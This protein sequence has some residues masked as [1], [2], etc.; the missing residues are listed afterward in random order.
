MFR[1]A[2]DKILEEK[3]EEIEK[4]TRHKSGML[5]YYSIGMTKHKYTA[6][7][8]GELPLIKGH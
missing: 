6:Q 1:I 3:Q 7:I 4:L 8:I 2:T 5:Q